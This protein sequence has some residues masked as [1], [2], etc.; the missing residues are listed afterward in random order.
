MTWRLFVAILSISGLNCGTATADDPDAQPR[1]VDQSLQCFEVRDGFEV[2]VVASEPQVQDP[3]SI[4]WAPDGRLLVVEMAGYPR[5]PQRGRIRVLS[6]ADRDGR[7]E[8]SEIFAD[9][10]SFPTSVQPWKS[11]VL[12][13][14]A[15]DILYLE[16]RNGDGVADHQEIWFSGFTSGNPQHQINHLEWGLDNRFHCSNGDVGGVVDSTKTG[17][18]V[19]IHG[20]DF[21]FSPVDR[22]MQTLTGMSQYGRCRNDW[23]DWVGCNNLIPGWQ[24][25]IQQRYLERNMHVHYP[26]MSVP[27]LTPGMAGPVYPIGAKRQRLNE[28]DLQNRFTSACGPT[29]FREAAWGPR[30]Q[31]SYFVCE[32]AH[33][34][35]RHEWID[36]RAPELS[37][38]TDADQQ[39]E[40]L[41]S[42]D[43]WFR[44][45]QVR[46]G[47][48]GALWV[49]DMY[50]RVIEH[51]EYIP[52]T[53]HEKLA[54]REGE[55]HGRIY[56]IVKRDVKLHPKFDVDDLSGPKLAKQLAT[57]NGTRRDLVHQRILAFEFKS[58]AEELEA[59][60]ADPRPEVRLSAL[61]VLDGL[62][63]LDRATLIKALS[64]K[65]SAVRRFAVEACELRLDSDPAI[66]E[67][68]LKRMDD[69]DQRVRLQLALSLGEWQ[70][71]R[72]A[73]ALA[74]LAVCD[75][76]SEW[77]I[78]AVLSSSSNNARSVLKSVL[79]L[80]EQVDRKLA[81]VEQLLPAAMLT[82]DHVAAMAARS[83]LKNDHQ[84]W[85]FRVLHS[86]L[87][88]VE[89]QGSSLAE[90]QQHDDDRQRQ[91][92]LGL[93][94]VIEQARQAIRGNRLPADERVVAIRLLGRHRDT[95]SRDQKLIFQSLEPSAPWVVHSAAIAAGLRYAD[96]AV[97]QRFLQRWGHLGPRQRAALLEA[98]VF[99]PDWLQVLMDQIE[100]GKISAGALA[101]SYRGR[102]LLHRDT[103]VQRRAAK[104]FTRPAPR[105]AVID[106]YVQADPEQG[107][108]ARGLVL[109]KKNCIGCHRFRTHGDGPGPALD[110]MARLGRKQLLENILDPSRAVEPRYVE[111]LIRTTDGRSLSGMVKQTTGQTLHL[112]DANAQTT[113]VKFD[114]IESFQSRERSIMPANW[115]STLSPA[116]MADLLAFLRGDR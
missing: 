74:K 91:V 84:P 58:A 21:S 37:S 104:L 44:P 95:W 56:R 3:I 24:A 6:D 69:D 42:R 10:L 47:P 19:W 46:T 2:Q 81:I 113:I 18:S 13:T 63:A 114:E 31:N 43:L 39:R 45:V 5:D 99:K 38:Q 8:R 61:S 89:R 82:D 9:G 49:V 25:V 53:L 7:F 60:A 85:R 70:D 115:E 65:H 15:P 80:P 103:E 52:K 26:M 50:R 73:T 36:D 64:D 20:L 17:K 34:L 106:Q 62:E 105:Q 48:D 55:G 77:M 107:N 86:L 75:A 28:L 97:F 68:F 66:A 57:S 72:A 93:N 14:C 108:A 23:G 111:Y 27:L 116:Q 51:P 54:F 16:D 76:E 30:F 71:P 67:P 4:A 96:A 98:A 94:D 12:V 83:I 22:S 59:V 101:E 90:L 110:A 33:G 100:A 102:I 79:N 88:T 78:A 109:F 35:V 29:F 11:G 40:F 41:A 1:S 87:T 112:F 32:P 92:F